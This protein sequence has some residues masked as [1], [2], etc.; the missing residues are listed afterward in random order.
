[1]T[2]AEWAGGRLLRHL[3]SNN[4]WLAEATLAPRKDFAVLLVTNVSDGVVEAPFKDL[5]AA[6]IADHAAHVQ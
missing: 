5:L 4:F 1:M 3:G 2:E 6:L